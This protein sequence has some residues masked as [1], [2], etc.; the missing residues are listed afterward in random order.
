MSDSGIMPLD[1]FKDIV[2]GSS[3]IN[4]AHLQ[5]IVGIPKNDS[6]EKTEFALEDKE[7][8][9]S[10][11]N[12]EV[13]VEKEVLADMLSQESIVE[14]ETNEIF[15]EED[16]T[17]ITSE[18]ETDKTET[19]EKVDIISVQNLEKCSLE[20]KN[21]VVKTRLDIVQNL[22]D[23]IFT[24]FSLTSINTSFFG[25]L[26]SELVPS[27]YFLQTIGAHS[28][29]IKE[30]KSLN[31]SSIISFLDKIK[32]TLSSSGII[33]VP[34][35]FKRNI[36]GSIIRSLVLSEKELLEIM[37]IYPDY[38][39]GYTD[40]MKQIDDIKLVIRIGGDDI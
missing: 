18:Y 22:V 21:I 30:E 13:L 17:E 33:S 7:D 4:T 36:E 19:K 40:H 25:D 32:P 14:V 35:V 38:Q 5:K 10:S 12:E 20:E 34:M 16:K 8:V 11:Q 6:F 29:F 23:D 37:K 1:I 26:I 24:S 28:F 39:F 9:S 2:E 15:I 3:K 27:G 31:L